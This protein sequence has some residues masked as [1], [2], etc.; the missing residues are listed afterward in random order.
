MLKTYSDYK[1]VIYD[2]MTYAGNMDNLYEV[3]NEPQFYFVQ[4]DICDA[5][6]VV[7]AIQQFEID[8]IV[9]FAAETHVDR[10]LLEP[11]SF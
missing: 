8:T 10:S 7:Q 4:G 5:D 1:I 2:A 9:N 11:E 6:K 3:V